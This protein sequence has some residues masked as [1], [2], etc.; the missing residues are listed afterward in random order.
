MFH[1]KQWEKEMKL[2]LNEII[3]KISKGIFPPV[4]V[5]GD[6]MLDRYQHGEVERISPEAPVP[7]VRIVEEESRLGG[8]A[9][10]AHNIQTLGGRVEIIGAIGR[11]S[12]GETLKSLLRRLNIGLSLL[13]LEDYPTI[14]KTRIIARRQQMVRVDRED[15]SRDDI[16][17]TK[18]RGLVEKIKRWDGI[19]VLS[20]YGK[21]LFGRGSLL[22]ILGSCEYTVLDPKKK[23]FSHYHNPY[24]ITPNREEA[25][26]L[27]GVPLQS[28]EDILRGGREIIKRVKCKNLLITL[29]PRGMVL[30]E[31][32]G[33][34]YIPSCAREV[35]DVTGAGDT[36]VAVIA[37]GLARGLSLLEACV[38]ANFCA[39]KVVGKV[40]T[41][42]VEWKEI[43]KDISGWRGYLRLE[44]W[45]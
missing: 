18:G 34:H 5:V 32:R 29:G 15:T 9:N 7:V 16:L 28:K 10:V 25:E 38:F 2:F 21:G 27:G 26:A 41:A 40:G 19:V 13:E 24:I 33:V 8:A 36:V 42:T 30:F 14:E 23:N 44:R 22:E 3:N 1:M 11:D 45:A 35:F 4:L 43:E 6:I 12:G 20:D 17:Y 39:G 37:L 31:K